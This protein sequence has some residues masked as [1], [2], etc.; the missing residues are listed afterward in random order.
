MGRVVHFEIAADDVA[1]AKKFY[2]IFGWSFTDSGMQGG[3]YWLAKTGEGGMGIDG[4]IM[5]RAYNPK[6]PIR[7]TIAVD[8]IDAMI[9]QVK[10]AGG[11]VEGEKGHIEGV[12]YYINA[13]DT[14][15]NQF[16]ILQPEPRQGASS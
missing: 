1:R 3:E 12:G 11:Q 2:E 10:A 9:E 13:R 15:G 5:T 8:D 16:G 4:A 7:N 6:Q 14:E